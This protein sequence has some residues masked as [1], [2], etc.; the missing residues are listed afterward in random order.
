MKDGHKVILWFCERPSNKVSYSSA[1][2]SLEQTFF[3]HV[4][5]NFM[6]EYDCKVKSFYFLTKKQPLLHPNSFGLILHYVQ[7]VQ[8]IPAIC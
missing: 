7:I 5:L 2:W 3:L 8:H 4:S 6:K 1:L